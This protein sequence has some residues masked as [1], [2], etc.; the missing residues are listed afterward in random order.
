MGLK[1]REEG[2]NGDAVETWCAGR[3]I[4]GGG[5]RVW[6]D[7]GGGTGRSAGGRGAEQA[8]CNGEAG[9]SGPREPAAVYNGGGVRQPAA[10]GGN[11]MPGARNH[12]GGD[13]VGAG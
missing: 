2:L 9:C 12:R 5:G 6:R 3:S 10:C 4:E 1:F 13:E 11:W 7:D 8:G